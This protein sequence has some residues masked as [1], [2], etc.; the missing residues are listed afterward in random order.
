MQAGPLDASRRTIGVVVALASVGAG[1]TGILG[2]DQTTL[3]EQGASTDA[4]EDA[5]DAAAADGTTSDVANDAPTTDS[6]APNDGG[7]RGDAGDAGAVFTTSPSPLFLYTDAS[8]PVQVTVQ[9]NGELPGALSIDFA[10]LPMG[11]TSTT[12]VIGGGSG[13]PTSLTLAAS[14]SA[15]TGSTTIA[16]QA[17]STTYAMVPLTVAGPPGSVDTTFQGGYVTAAFSGAI[18]NSV[19]VDAQGGLIAGGT[20]SAGGWLL[21]RYSPEGADDMV[22]N[23]KAAAIMPTM[24]SLN[25]LSIDASNGRIVCVGNTAASSGELTATVL[26]ATG[27]ADGAFNGGLPFTT[28]P[29]PTQGSASGNAVVILQT[30]T[31]FVAG[32]DTPGHNAALSEPI[33]ET[34]MP[35]MSNP[36]MYV[37]PTSST[38]FNAAAVDPNEEIVAAG[39]I[40]GGPPDVLVARFKSSGA[41]DS[42][43]GSSGTATTNALAC[44]GQAVVVRPISGSIFV[45]GTD[46]SGGNLPGCF[47]EFAANGSSTY[48]KDG[49][50]GGGGPFVY[51]GV[52]A[53]GD[54]ADRIYMVG[55]GGDM[56]SRSAELDRV[57][58]GGVFDPTFGG[59]GQVQLDPGG[60]PPAYYFTLRAVTV[61]PDGRVV[62][63]GSRTNTTTGTTNPVIGRFWP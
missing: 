59:T 58:V 31:F 32:A 7:R 41:L 9:R 21:R 4:G 3:R 42:T 63:A 38:V 23:M 17:N 12:G 53:M 37:E 57:S 2:L 48:I 61:Q 40:P 19:A 56:F 30:Q 22:F 51:A 14:G 16:L 47:G 55:S 52:A 24:G 25:A 60:S 28:S 10:Q 8:L 50:P 34:G 15:T 33:S 26:Q 44:A 45:A 35:N 11:V 1:C 49:T 43:F 18:F 6:P 54:S 29:V 27:D 5:R 20:L 13:G 39:S 36:F 46:N 62:I